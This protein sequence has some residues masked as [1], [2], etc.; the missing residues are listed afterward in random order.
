MNKTR[1]TDLCHRISDE[2]GLNFNS[3]LT[4]Y[5][6]EMFLSKLS[7]SI[8]N[9]NFIFKGG[10]ILSNIVG[11]ESRS[12]V[13]IDMLI[14]KIPLSESMVQKIIDD[15]IKYEDNDIIVY[16]LLDITEIMKEG[17]YTGYRVRVSCRFENIN[18]VIPLDI[19]TGDIVTYEP[20]EY[21]Y[22]SIFSDE[23]L[24]IN[25][26]NIETMLA[27][28]LETIYSKGML[29][30][31]I[32]DFYD[33]YLLYNIKRNEINFEK[34][35]KACSRTFDKRG[36]S[37]DVENF[38]SLLKDIECNQKFNEMWSTY[39]RKNAYVN[40]YAFAEIVKNILNLLLETFN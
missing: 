8:Y 39:S 7:K 22:K 20:L 25:T 29:N 30:S 13:D 35:A 18:Q 38:K 34:L 14:N 32:K 23:N 12:T 31:R 3:V 19:A 26:Y 16:R 21:E 37:M 24:C 33:V 4:Y 15:V 11:L 36:T 9:K 40:D 6:L 27:E 10:Y 2:T 5:F 1:L 28:K 17:S